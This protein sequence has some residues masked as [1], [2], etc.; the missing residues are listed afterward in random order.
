MYHAVNSQ[1]VGALEGAGTELA[2]V[3]SLVYNQRKKDGIN[4][5]CFPYMAFLLGL[6]KPIK[7]QAICVPVWCFAWRSSCF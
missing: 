5:R 4:Y 6:F 1:I 7:G 2:D 3:I